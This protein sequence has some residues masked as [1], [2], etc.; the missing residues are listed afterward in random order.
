MC[1]KQRKENDRGDDGRVPGQV[2][3]CLTSFVTQLR[4]AP[5]SNRSMAIFCQPLS[6]AITNAVL[7][8][9]LVALMSMPASI[10]NAGK[11]AG[12]KS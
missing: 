5:R 7:F 9:L 4:S 2:I 10:K 11:S 8:S 3:L 12:G 1:E 6:R